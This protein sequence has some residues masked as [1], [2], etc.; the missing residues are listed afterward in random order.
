MQFRNRGLPRHCALAVVLF[1]CL[2]GLAYA[3]PTAFTYQGKLTDAGS[4]ANGN[5]D[6]Q[7]KLYDTPGLGTGTQ[8]GPTRVVPVV[9]ASA[10]IFAVTLDF[11]NSF[12]ANLYLEIGVRPAGS[13]NAYALLAARQAIT[14]SPYAIETINAQMLA[15]LP[16]TRYVATDPAGNVGVGTASPASKLHIVSGAG[17]PPPRVQ[18]SS[19]NGFSAGW[20]FYLN[21][22]GAGYVGVP[23]V[24]APF[25]A[26]EL[27]LYGGP[28]VPTSIWANT[29]RV[30]TLTTLGN[31]GIGTANPVNGKLQVEGGAG[32]GIYGN[33]TSATAVTGN[34]GTNTG[35]YGNSNSGTGV[36]GTS[37]SYFGVYGKSI[38]F[39]GVRGE[40]AAG[41]GAGVSG[42]NTSG[43][44][45]G[46]LGGSTGSTGVGVQG[47]SPGGK[48]VVGTST[49]GSGVY[50]E[51]AA[52]SVTNGGV[53]G[54][55]LGSGSIGVI[56]ESNINNA[57][58]VFGASASA[59]GY[60]VFARNGGGGIALYAEGNVAQ[61]ADKNGV[62]KAMLVV[63]GNIVNN[64][65]YISHCYNGVTG[66]SSG[67]CGFALSFIGPGIYRI[68]FGFPVVNRFVVV[69]PRY[70]SSPVISGSN[71]I[72]AN[73]RVLSGFPN[74]GEVFTFHSGNSANT[75]EASFNM[76]MY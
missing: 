68:D 53:Y 31:V 15:G 65:A 74:I 27:I 63:E 44:G 32:F 23:D 39:E 8:H 69:T 14:S 34:S 48:G 76:V 30:M 22:G 46:V 37:G 60:G 71:N 70:A 26:G 9:A 25:G 19:T 13:P 6:M 2:V 36:Y 29:T 1:F 55:G 54:K 75:I 33:S 3:V 73:Y 45:I 56:G 64:A 66:A 12:D 47:N 67:N 62:V 49:S 57:V 20:D 52:A 18:S 50:G 72:G 61:P 42:Y 35:V 5:Y 43:G 7:F 41:S 16:A 28:G 51:S 24:L 10:G 4:P 21:A 17:Q 58:G 40:T 11:G 59:T 38:N